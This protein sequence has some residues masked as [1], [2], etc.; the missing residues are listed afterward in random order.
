MTQEK[1]V[2]GGRCNLSSCTSGK[3]AHWY[4]RGSL[5][6][7]CQRCALMLNA[8]HRSV[9]FE[10]GKKMVIPIPQSYTEEE[11]QEAIK[12]VACREFGR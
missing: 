7:Y 4:N 3:P 8:I 9:L 10:D 2:R 5:S 1:G 11:V 12:F 6:W